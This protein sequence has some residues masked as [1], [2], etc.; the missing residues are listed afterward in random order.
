VEILGTERI[1]IPVCEA[2]GLDPNRV[3]R[4]I[5]DINA[6]VGGPVKVYVEMIA[7]E[8]MLTLDWSEGLREGAEIL[9]VSKEDGWES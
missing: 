3:S 9:R 8:R 7:D 2:L 1:G 6:Y 4:I 5:I